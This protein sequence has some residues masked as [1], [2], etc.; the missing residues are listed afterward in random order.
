MKTNYFLS[1]AFTLFFSISNAQV[2]I[3]TTIPDGALDVVSTNDGLLI[4]RVVLTA[5][6]VATVLT[7][8]ES[9][10]VYNTT[11]SAPGPNAVVKGYYFWNGTLWVK[12]VTGDSNDD[13][14][15]SGNTGSSVATNFLGT[16][17]DS[18]IAFRRNN[19]RAGFIGNPAAGALP[20]TPNFRNTTFG[21]NSLLN[22]AGSYSNTAIGTNVMTSNLGGSKN[23]GVGENALNFNKN[24][25]ENTGIGV[26][27]LSKNNG[28]TANTAVGIG[29]LLSNVGGT[30]NTAV[31][32]YSLE[33]NTIGVNNTAIGRN[34]L[35]ANIIGQQNVATGSN[36]L[37]K[38]TESFNT[39]NGNQ[40]LINNTTGTNNT[41][42]GNQA[43]AGTALTAN[44]ST[45]S[46]NTAI[47]NQS[48]YNNISGIGN[49][50][51]GNR[52]GFSEL[53]D[54]KLYIEN[55]GSDSS[56]A[57]IYGEFDTNVLRT[58][59]TFQIGN[60]AGTGYAFP[61]TRPGTAAG[62]I[63]Q[64]NTLGA[65][66]FQ[67]PAVALNSYAWLTTG[68]TAIASNFIG[69]I[70]AIPLRLFSNNLERMRIK[71]DGEVVVNSINSPYPV[72]L[73]SA[74][75]N[76]TTL[77][78]AVNGYS[79]GNGSG[80]WGEIRLG[81]TTTE[82]GVDG[83]YG[84]T[85]LGAGTRGIYAGTNTSN[86]RSGVRGTITNNANGGA[87]V[88]GNHEATIGNQHMGVLGTYNT[89]DTWGL[90]VVGI[91]AGGS[92]P[93]GNQDIAIVG[94]RAN[95]QNYSGYFNGNHVIANGT[96]SASVGT[97]KGNQLL[98]VT[99][100]PEVWF[101]DLGGATLV[102][103]EASIK[104]D[105]LFLETV[106][107]DTKHPMR[108]FLQ[109]EGE[110]EGLIVIKDNDNKGFRV[111]EKNGGQSNISFSYRIMAKRLHFQDHRFGSDPVW[112]K[113]DTR[114][115]N[116]YAEPPA[117]NYETKV[118]QDQE[119][120][121]NYKPSPMPDG[122]QDAMQLNSESKKIKTALKLEKK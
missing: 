46:F 33:N 122:F 47:G 69:T 30:S 72:D 27:A 84:G 19:I 105:P 54:N 40:A 16:I 106:F 79:V 1:L 14:N 107:V 100:A 82:S 52:A 68:N 56:N 114:I 9:E 119:F 49:V 50:G 22:P 101:E 86:L 92:I 41:A 59:S 18:D 53:G 6:N 73:F 109:E 90:G 63:L 12:L 11:A 60:P 37:L 55:S 31:G 15:L 13:W 85:G 48:F 8:V 35:N 67:T 78:Y 71:D 120:K 89:T 81:N 45:G 51:I 20:T 29:S 103:G 94:W 7:P 2:G 77:T 95:N 66:T 111:K 108:I 75:G 62:Q 28:G 25:S 83:I 4:P 5:T 115:Y 110:S 80:V 26:D 64:H 96:K 117:T 34:A 74:S 76:T 121:K 38:N 102:N 61:T 17:D 87:A 10:L 32:S 36:A 91:S 42:V 88:F 97:S 39:A 104:L 23:V 58:N 43:L 24:G 118:R 98:Y 116:Q 57:L 65:L 99:E 21:A 3:G 93:T 112:G 70:N 113:G 44:V